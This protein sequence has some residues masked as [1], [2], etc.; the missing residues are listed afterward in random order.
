MLAVVARE[1]HHYHTIEMSMLGL[2]RIQGHGGR[3]DLEEPISR[4]ILTLHSSPRSH[5]SSPSNS[6]MVEACLERH[7][8]FWRE[9]M[10]RHIFEL[11]PYIV[12]L[13]PVLCSECE[14]SDC[15]LHPEYK[16]RE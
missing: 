2:E 9:L 12:C 8:R 5:C 14:V 1:E 15:P 13:C 10:G 4:P 3:G 7:W 11:L 16:A 6:S